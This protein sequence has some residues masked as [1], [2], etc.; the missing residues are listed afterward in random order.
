MRTRFYGQTIIVLCVLLSSIHSAA[1][2]FEIGPTIY[3]LTLLPFKNFSDPSFFAGPYPT[4]IN[5]QDM[6][7][8][9][10]VSR[11]GFKFGPAG[12]REDAFTNLTVGKINNAGEYV[13][14]RSASSH[15]VGICGCIITRQPTFPSGTRFEYA[16]INNVGQITGGFDPGTGLA[17]VRGFVSTNGSLTFFQAPNFLL[18]S[19]NAVNDLGEVVGEGFLYRNGTITPLSGNA[20][21]INNA[22][23]ILFANG[24]LDRDGV[25]TPIS[26]PDATETHLTALNNRGHIAGWYRVTKS[27]H[28]FPT[29]YAFILAPIPEPSTWL[30]LST[31]LAALLYRRRNRHHKPM[32]KQ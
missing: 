18:T 16:G 6:T 2:T 10:E 4:G 19:P 14:T 11:I 20:V 29:D 22:G 13:A 21:D 25:F 5:D 9:Y 30:L 23:D 28:D 1:S 15:T 7:I 31:G 17:D 24:L 3:T 12:L 8:G 27:I 26:V 32:Q